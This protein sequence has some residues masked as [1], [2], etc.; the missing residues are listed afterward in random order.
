MWPIADSNTLE[1]EVE[2]VYIIGDVYTGPSTVVECIASGRLAVES[3]IDAVLG[4]E[5]EDEH[6]FSD[7]EEFSFEESEEMIKAED[8]FFSE[9]AEK[10]GRILSSKAWGDAEFAYTEALR[11]TECSYIC[12]K[13]VDVCPN[14]ANVAIDVRNTGFFEDPFQILHLDAFCNECGNCETF[15]PYDGGPYKEKFTLFNTMEDFTDSTNSGF[16]SDGQELWVRLDEKTIECEIDGDGLIAADAPLSD[17]A[18]AV[19][20]TVYTRYSYL[21][22]C[23]EE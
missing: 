20:E 13:C 15:C 7:E 2:G 5:E 23:V 10:R 18:A 14:R 11:C 22:G 6:D 1:S 4:P 12:D 19:I 16:F 21:L 9:L 17:E 8:A 3:A